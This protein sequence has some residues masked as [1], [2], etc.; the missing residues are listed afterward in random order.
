MDLDLHGCV[1]HFLG[2]PYGEDEWQLQILRK[3]AAGLDRIVPHLPPVLSD[4]FVSAQGLARA[5]LQEWDE[6]G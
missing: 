6:A 2:E 1:V 5:L 3:V 4:Y